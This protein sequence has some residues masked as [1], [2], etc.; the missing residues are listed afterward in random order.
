[1]KKHKKT[2]LVNTPPIGKFLEVFGDVR[3]K[4]DEHTWEKLSKEGVGM[5]R[6]LKTALGLDSSYFDLG[7]EI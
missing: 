3:V 6:A 4:I 2:F 1:M 7:G 5:K